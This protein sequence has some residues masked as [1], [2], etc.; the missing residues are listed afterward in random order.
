MNGG[1]RDDWLAD[2]EDIPEDP[3]EDLQAEY[4]DLQEDTRANPQAEYADL[5][6]DRPGR[7]VFVVWERSCAFRS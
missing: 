2:K 7:Q 1:D 5:Q 4:A 3:Q 6:D